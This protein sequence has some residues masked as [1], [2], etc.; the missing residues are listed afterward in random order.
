MNKPKLYIFAIAL[1]AG[2][3]A[4]AQTTVLA[5]FDFNESTSLPQNANTT[6]SNITASINGSESDA[7]YNGTATGSSAF[8]QNTTAGNAMSMSGNTNTNT[9]T[10][11]MG[12][13]NLYLYASYKLYF[14]AQRSSTGATT[15][16]LS[17]S[18][19]GTNFTNVSTTASPGNGSFAEATIDLS[20]ITAINNASALYIKFSGS[21][22]TNNGGTLRLDNL[23][24]QGTESASGTN[25]NNTFFNGN[26]GIGTNNPAYPLD[27]VGAARISGA[28]TSG[29]ATVSSLSN[30][31]A[32]TLTGAV[33][34]GALTSGA[35]TASSLTSTG[36][37]SVT[38]T[39]NLTGA[40]TTGALTSGATN[41][42]SLNSSGNLS[43]SGTTNLIGGVI[44]P[45]IPQGS[46][47]NRQL[48]VDPSGNLRLGGGVGNIQSICGT[49][50]QWSIGGD[51]ITG[52]TPGASGD[53]ALGTCDNNPFILKSHGVQSLFLVPNT[54]TGLQSLLGVGTSA[55]KSL[56]HINTQNTGS[57]PGLIVDNASPL[58][59]NLPEFMVNSDGSTVINSL[60]LTANPNND[61][62]NI[63][64]QYDFGS[65]NLV[66]NALR[67]AFNSADAT[68]HVGIG[69]SN[70]YVAGST[71]VK[72]STYK[73][74][75]VNGDVSLANYNSAGFGG[76]AV[77]GQNGI[78]ILGLD[79]VPTRR[80]IA[81]DND[82][83]GD[84]NFY[85]N[86]NQGSSEFN[87]KNG[88]N[89]SYQ[90]YSN[91]AAA[92]NLM[93]INALGEVIIK[94]L[95]NTTSTAGG[96]KN[97]LVD[98][99][100][101]LIYG[102]AVA[103][104]NSAAWVTGGNTNG[105]EQ[106]IGTKDGYDLPFITG[107]GAEAM[108]IDAAGNVLINTATST[109]PNYKKTLTVNGDVC[110][111]NYASTGGHPNDGG[112]GL[113]ILGD[114]KLPT[115]RG[116][117]VDADPNG[118]FN[119]YINS[120]QGGGGSTAA[121]FNFKKHN[122]TDGVINLMTLNASGQLIL[123]SQDPITGNPNL[124]T[125]NSTHS[126]A[127]LQVKGDV[128]VGAGSAANLFVTQTGWADFVFDNNYKL[129][130]LNEVEK[131][132]KTNHH[133]PN[134]PTQKDIQ[135]Q[136][137]NLGQTDVVLLQKIEENTLYIVEL[138]KQLE[139]QQKLIEELAK[140]IAV[141]K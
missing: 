87:F 17:Y 102:A 108:R 125:S 54:T 6:A 74:L 115:S 67:V 25:G 5:N 113:E 134:V 86:S 133:L 10:L 88:T 49:G 116:I 105:S 9:W 71:P 132:Y 48:L 37:L 24:I 118:D 126:S 89:S 68:G 51:N 39:S 58:P 42:S 95:P 99:N 20:S 64:M 97:V 60:P 36:N 94:Q 106:T 90:N 139:T 55:P 57:T 8:V 26:V 92:P 100:G 4:T 43:V 47:G 32:T 65:L 50:I 135:E 63:N 119:F 15:I 77:D 141:K 111:A 66:T 109:S 34:T 1:L 46:A 73:T 70:Y 53:L 112:S 93:T 79:K 35:H 129:M 40:V 84:L 82:P 11:N 45:T 30:S 72:G 136:G 91:G 83:T 103:S 75:T 96:L 23:E 2:I 69:T 33:T 59:T 121:E 123:G 80:G 61:A 18:T 22:S 131:F 138:K 38:G 19:D 117:T 101:K 16:T 98:A 140:K 128:V 7:A 78:E 85:I 31:G 13:S 120:W 130:P 137:N 52:V 21:G 44:I 27:V 12:G 3:T 41:V 76:S 14:Q 124:P 104:T 122:P 29:A 107:T 114:N 62:F 127:L 110:F 28:L 56:L 81:T